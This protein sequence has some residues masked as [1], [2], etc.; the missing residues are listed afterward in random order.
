MHYS[1]HWKE[2][3]A[4]LEQSNLTCRGMNMN[5]L[6]CVHT[7]SVLLLLAAAAAKPRLNNRTA[8]N[9]LQTWKKKPSHVVQQHMEDGPHLPASQHPS[10]LSVQRH[11]RHVALLISRASDQNGCCFDGRF[12]ADEAFC[13]FQVAGGCVSR[14]RHPRF[15]FMFLGTI[16]PSQSGFL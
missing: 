11:Q 4:K 6:C 14:R 3:A 9:W 12:Y 15:G 2:E 7:G 16:R 10:F 1:W 13:N 8:A 5:A